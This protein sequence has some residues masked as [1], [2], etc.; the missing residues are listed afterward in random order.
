MSEIKFN[1]EETLQT[2]EITMNKLAV[3]ARLRP[4]TIV[5]LTHGDSKAIKFDTLI[6]ILDTLNYFAEEKRIERVF[7]IHDVIEYVPDSK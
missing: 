5:E 7:T 6:K 1:L 3:Q 4:T 2:L